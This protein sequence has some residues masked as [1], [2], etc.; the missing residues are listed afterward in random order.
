MLEALMAIPEI[1][2]LRVAKSLDE[3]C[4]RIPL[5]IRNKLS[6]HWSIR[7]N[8]VTLYER[9]PHWN[10]PTSF[11]DRPFARFVYAPDSNSWT[12][13][14]FDRNQKTHV[15]LSFQGVRNFQKLVDEV[16]SDPTG[17]FLG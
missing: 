2:R 16:R 1:A 10:D 6:N 12:L 14:C 9:R 5:N 8:Q 17:I 7:G 15:Y 11:S 4:D 13:R 3:F